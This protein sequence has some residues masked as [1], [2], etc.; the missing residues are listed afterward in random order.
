M[1]YGVA[2]TVLIP[3]IAMGVFY[4]LPQTMLAASIFPEVKKGGGTWRSAEGLESQTAPH[5]QRLL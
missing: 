4:F 5:A 3:V 1:N 2:V